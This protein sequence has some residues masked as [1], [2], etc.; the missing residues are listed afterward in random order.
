MTEELPEGVKI[1]H[2]VRLI[3]ISIN[4]FELRWCASK[5]EAHDQVN[6]ARD[7]TIE[8]EDE[9][10]AAGKTIPPQPYETR[11]P[12]EAAMRVHEDTDQIP[13]EV[14]PRTLRKVA[15][16]RDKEGRLY[17][18]LHDDRGS[19][20]P[21]RLYSKEAALEQISFA[22]RD[23]TATAEERIDQGINFETELLIKQLLEKLIQDSTLSAGLT[24]QEREAREAV[25]AT[26]DPHS[27]DFDPF[28]MA[29]LLR[30]LNPI[31][32]GVGCEELN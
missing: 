28:L 24:D 22:L 19:A 16:D 12:A 6:E 32:M 11:L 18:V 25:R 14:L 3:N 1:T 2:S 7:L 15:F 13:E 10:I 5:E 8:I 26:D 17:A 20:G 29:V 27:A 30:T 31:T 4:G 23:K 9:E 21:D